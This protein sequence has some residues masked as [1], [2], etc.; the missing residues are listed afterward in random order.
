MT[1]HQN[2]SWLPPTPASF[3]ATCRQLP[4]GKHADIGAYLR[5]QAS[6]ALDL[7][8][9]NRLSRAM[10]KLDLSGSSLMP[11][12]LGV[13]SNSTTEYIVPAIVATGAR[14][15]LN[16]IPTVADYGQVAQTALDP[17]SAINQVQLDAVLLALDHHAQSFAV[18]P[19]D[20]KSAELAVQAAADFVDQVRGALKKHSGA[21][22][23]VQTIPRPAESFLGSYD[24]VM[25]GSPRTLISE[26]NR[27]IA[28]RISGSTDIVFDV[29]G[30]AETVGLGAW[31]DA[32]I[33]NLAKQ[34]F[35][36]DMIPLYADHF[37]RVL[38]AMKGRSKKV[39]VLDLDNTVWGGIIGDDG[40]EGI[41]IA[42]GDATGEAHL[43]L[44][45]V[46]LALRDRGVVLAVSSKNDDE[47]ARAVFRQHPEMLLREEHIAVFQ[48]NWDDKAT[49]I[50]AIA[51]AL[52]LGLDSFVFVDD[53]PVERELVRRTL[54]QVSVPELPEDPAN[55]S[56]TLLAAGYFEAIGFSVEDRKRADFYSDNARRLVLQQKVGDLDEYLRSLQMTIFFHPFDEKGQARISQL[57]NKSNQFNLTTRR[58]TEN[59]VVKMMS[60]PDVFTLQ[61]R[62]TDMFGDNGMIS[63]VI[64]RS[65]GRT[66]EI[67]TWLMSCRVLGRR[68]EE[69]VLEEIAGEAVKQGVES[70]LG[71]Y[72]PTSK[73]ALVKDHYKKLDF[74]H[75]ATLDDGGTVWRLK[76]DGSNLDS[77]FQG[78]RQ[79]AFHP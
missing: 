66:W 35:S 43:E 61:V 52:S 76:L 18:V 60:D 1:L 55:Y 79:S 51:D 62:L 25:P 46:A 6:H 22:V 40:M 34:P 75:E 45:R 3:A 74:S 31:H 24:A 78:E 64:C 16:I 26:L 77:G 8:D 48:A 19:G 41:K 59:D 71:V 9:L 36:M 15:G 33:W 20:L 58:Y 7:N 70:L 53:N 37:C 50:S 67:D 68:V 23:I 73:N 42:Q 47:I 72:R 30:L 2:L 57:I 28:R 4:E 38:A 32:K 29:S 39:L 54:P 13:L 56:R 65:Q 27:E 63:V 17:N 14:Y 10:A 44:Q 12:R 21:A 11:I 5:F 69:A 49:N